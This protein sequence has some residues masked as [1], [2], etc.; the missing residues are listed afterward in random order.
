MN[1]DK[2][3]QSQII[4]WMTCDICLNLS[5]HFL[6]YCTQN[7]HSFCVYCIS[8]LKKNN[9][10]KCPLCRSEQIIL[11]KNIIDGT[12]RR[13]IMYWHNLFIRKLHNDLDKYKTIRVDAQ[14][15]PDKKW[16][17]AE[18]SNI[19]NIGYHLHYIGWGSRFDEIFPNLKNQ[20]EQRI[21]PLSTMTNT[22]NWLNNLQINDIVEYLLIT[23]HSRKWYKG[24]IC[25]ISENRKFIHIQN[26]NTKTIL[27]LSMTLHRLA[28]LGTHIKK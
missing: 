18:L 4:Q 20:I 9:I 27:K 13:I 16:Y 3:I 10:E 19:P 14:D 5:K 7:G 25:Y 2:I 11:K 6:I 8:K 22:S 12:R 15:F 28:P 21:M 17:E 1:D 23:I 26:N 24:N